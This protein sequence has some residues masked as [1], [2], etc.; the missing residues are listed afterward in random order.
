MELKM[1]FLEKP[2]RANNKE[3][4]FIQVIP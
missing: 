4:F 3:N 2:K 1:P